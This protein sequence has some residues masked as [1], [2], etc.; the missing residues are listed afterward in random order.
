MSGVQGDALDWALA[1]A[2]AP[3]ERHALRQRA[4]PDGIETLIQIAG[5]GGADALA[6]AAAHTGESP[7][8]IV[9]AARFYLREVLFFPDADAYRLLG[10]SPDADAARIRSHHRLLQQ[11]LHPDRCSDEDAVFAA[12]VNVAWDQLRQP[13]RRAAYDL[14]HPVALA[15]DQ[16][17][18]AGYHPLRTW[19]PVAVPEV[20]EV[21]PQ[22]RWRRRVPLLV[23]L[24]A[25]LALGIITVRYQQRLDDPGSLPLAGVEKDDGPMLRVPQ[26]TEAAAPG[27]PARRERTSPRPRAEAR[28]TPVAAVADMIQDDPFQ[29]FVAEE[30]PEFEMPVEPE[31]A[32]AAVV[33]EAPPPARRPP[34]APSPTP[35]ARPVRTIAVAT[36]APAS[37]PA[38]VAPPRAVAV[39]PARTPAAVAPARTVAPAPAARIARAAAPVPD[40]VAVAT[41]APTRERPQ[42]VAATVPPP[43]AKAL[44]PVATAT[45]SASPKVAPATA[46]PPPAPDPRRVAV[47]HQVGHRL[48]AYLVQAGKGVPPI[49]DSLSA[50]RAAALVRDGIARGEGARFASPDWRISDTDAA[51]HAG[52]RYRDG[53]EGR[54]RARLIWREQRW[55]VSDLSL[56]QDW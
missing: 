41:P 13:D 29:P 11:W 18:D 47:A 36:P 55:L 20:V 16:G 30:D 39:A 17:S 1:L 56:E 32:R 15:Q 52:L 35:P 19:I 2:K 26:G 9:E 53:R 28:Q 43:Q 49:W 12:R 31:S 51:L 10:V 21:S 22:E 8:R 54:L 50:E 24:S 4:L 7:E 34:P 5:G 42:R 45:A 25:C 46:P 38:T 14:D 44:P 48:L 6:K 23:L 33:I 37:T 40:Q 27:A 3:A